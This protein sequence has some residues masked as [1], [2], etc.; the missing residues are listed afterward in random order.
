M[1]DPAYSIINDRLLSNSQES[2]E[3]NQDSFS[4]DE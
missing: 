1:E 2:G 4:L 3:E